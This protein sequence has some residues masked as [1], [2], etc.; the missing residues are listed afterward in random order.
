MAGKEASSDLSYD[1]FS[2][3]GPSPT[4]KDA[5][6]TVIHIAD[7]SAFNHKHAAMHADRVREELI[8]LLDMLPASPIYK[9]YG[10][11][12]RS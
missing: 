12:S 7:S 5:L 11:R 10:I 1:E 3:A 2:D 8:K 4:G 6:A 9:E